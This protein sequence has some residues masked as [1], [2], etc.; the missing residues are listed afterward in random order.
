[1]SQRGV[2]GSFPPPR[3][4]CRVGTAHISRRVAAR[5]PTRLLCGGFA[6]RLPGCS[7]GYT[8]ATRT[9]TPTKVPKG[10]PTPRQTPSPWGAATETLRF[11]AFGLSFF[12]PTLWGEPQSSAHPPDPPPRVSPSPPQRSLSRPGTRAAGCQGPAP[13]AA[14]PAAL[15]GAVSMV[16]RL[17]GGSRGPV[18]RGRA[19]RRRRL[20]VRG[21]TASAILDAAAA[22]VSASSCVFAVHCRF[23]RA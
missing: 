9:L 15:A 18:A 14:I 13:A 5:V 7:S 6:P 11:A 4:S 16:W 10:T 23:P 21:P 8:V 22:A 12:P 2:L 1:M 3:C 19:G 17:L 20:G